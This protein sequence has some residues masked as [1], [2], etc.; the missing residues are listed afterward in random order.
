MRSNDS[1]EREMCMSG[2]IV[3]YQQIICPHCFQEY[4]DN[5]WLC[6][7]DDLDS[8]KGVV[9]EHCRKKFD[10]KVRVEKTF[11]TTRAVEE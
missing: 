7:V 5:L 2:Q 4:G 11:T 6:L 8:E 1:Y 9:C 3:A 10:I